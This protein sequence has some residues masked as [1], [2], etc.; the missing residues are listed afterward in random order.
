M[1]GPGRLHLGEA[2]VGRHLLLLLLFFTATCLSP[3]GHDLHPVLQRGPAPFTDEAAI[4]NSTATVCNLRDGR[5]RRNSQVVDYRDGASAFGISS[6]SSSCDHEA[7]ADL[8]TPPDGSP[9]TIFPSWTLTATTPVSTPTL[10][11]LPDAPPDLPTFPFRELGLTTNELEFAWQPPVTPYSFADEFQERYGGLF[12]D[13]RGADLSGP[14][15]DDVCY[16]DEPQQQ[17]YTGRMRWVQFSDVSASDLLEDTQTYE[18]PRFTVNATV[19]DPRVGMSVL[20]ADIYSPLDVCP[21]PRPLT[22]SHTTFHQISST[23]G[24]AIPTPINAHASPGFDIDSIPNEVMLEIFRHLLVFPGQAVRVSDSN[25]PTGEPVLQVGIPGQPR[26]NDLR[27]PPLRDLLA[28]AATNPQLRRLALDQFFGYNTFDLTIGNVLRRNALRWIRGLPRQ[29]RE[30]LTR[31][32]ISLYL[33]PVTYPSKRRINTEEMIREIGKSHVLRSV[34]IKV[35]D[36]TDIRSLSPVEKHRRFRQMP[37]LDLLSRLRG[38]DNLVVEASFALEATKIRRLKQCLAKPK[39]R[40][41]RHD[42]PDLYPALALHPLSSHTLVKRLWSELNSE[43][44][45]YGL[46]PENIKTKISKAEELGRLRRLDW[47]NPDEPD[48]P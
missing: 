28:V 1:Y 7:V 11:E 9:V 24:N 26:H 41:G 47:K 38:V 32:E 35:R 4:F 5:E 19:I 6:I 23:T 30:W 37:G 40:R 17:G 48:E 34:T 44:E 25:H 12:A 27:L 3:A 43:L 33:G 39:G 14:E 20:A 22:N 29:Y 42:Q 31:V 46:N 8:L 13:Y 15:D 21:A 16:L 45:S 2:A 36:T 10:D 18:Q